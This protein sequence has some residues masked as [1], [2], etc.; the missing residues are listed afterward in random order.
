MQSLYLYGAMSTITSIM[1]NFE[2]LLLNL[3]KDNINLDS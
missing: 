1:Y 3:N 2:E